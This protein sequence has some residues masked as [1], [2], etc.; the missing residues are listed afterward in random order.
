MPAARHRRDAGLVDMFEMVGRKRAELGR[1]R[2]AVQIAELLG[3]ELD[4]QAVLGR[5]LEQRPH[6]VR[7]EADP[8]AKGVDRARP[9]PA[10]AAAGIMLSIASRTKSS[11]RSRNSGGSA[12]SA[13]RVG[14]TRTVSLSPSALA[15]CS[16]FS[17]VVDVEAVARLDLDRGDAAAHQRARAAAATASTSSSSEAARVALTVE[18]DAAAGAGDLLIGRAFEPL[19]ELARAVAAEDE[20]GVAVDQARRHPGAAERLDL[21]RLV[22]GELDPPADADDPA[23]LDADRAILDRAERR[24]HGRVHRRDVAVGRAAG[25]TWL[26]F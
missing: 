1:Q 8:L 13:S 14:T 2:G 3:V 5:R 16:I 25:P 4:P 12:W 24:R 20:M 11:R 6:L 18:S 17:S 23:V 10:S 7:R 19:L 21:P 15:A 9:G 26:A 22:A